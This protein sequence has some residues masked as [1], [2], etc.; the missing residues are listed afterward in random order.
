[1][2]LIVKGKT[3]GGESKSPPSIAEL[4][5]LWK[6]GVALAEECWEWT[7]VL[8]DQYRW[9]N[10]PANCGH[11]E[12]YDAKREYREAC[13]EFW[14]HVIERFYQASNRFG[15]R[16][17]HADDQTLGAVD[18]YVLRWRE[19]ALI[20]YWSEFPADPM[21]VNNSLSQ[22]DNEPPF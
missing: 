16:A 22:W 8:E 19:Y 2:A 3:R 13:N 9:I 20:Q 18:P 7:K 5:A 10:D 1:M 12:M 15:A 11:P 17:R 6:E 4:T 21:A 14:D